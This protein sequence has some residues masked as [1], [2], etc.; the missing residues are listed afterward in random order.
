MFDNERTMNRSILLPSFALAC[1][2][3]PLALLASE[4]AA[5]AAAPATSASSASP[6]AEAPRSDGTRCLSEEERNELR[7]QVRQAAEESSADAPT[8]AAVVE[9]LGGQ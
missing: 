7:E 9:K 8:A 5:P 3:A 2:A 1:I 6:P 4:A